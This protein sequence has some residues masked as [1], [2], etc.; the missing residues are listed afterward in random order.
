MGG[1]LFGGSVGG[2]VDGGGVEVGRVDRALADRRLED[3]LWPERHEV[4]LG[5]SAPH[6]SAVRNELFDIV[7]SEVGCQKACDREADTTFG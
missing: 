6:P 4:L 1:E 7:L 2:G 5:L 3:G